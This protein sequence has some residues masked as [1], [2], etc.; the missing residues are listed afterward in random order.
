MVHRITEAQYRVSKWGGGLTKQLAIAPKNAVY[1]DRDFLW[2]IS[3][4]TV[5]LEESDFTPLPDYNRFLSTLEG[6]IT[7]NHGDGM[8]H[9]LVPGQIH[10]FDGGVYTHSCGVCTDFNLMLR[11]GRCTGSMDC[12]RLEPGQEVAPMQQ[13]GGQL[14]VYCVKGTAALRD[15]GEIT[16]LSEGE[17]LLL[18]TADAPVLSAEESAVLMTAEMHPL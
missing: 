11:K 2:R 5:E 6:E 15:Q 1:A 4:A 7:L 17:A 10:A 14:L 18:D 9:H 13:S 3:S 12:I 8:V 16:H